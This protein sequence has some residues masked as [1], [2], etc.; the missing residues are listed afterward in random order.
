MNLSPMIFVA[1]FAVA[2]LFIK[3]APR[4]LVR[5]VARLFASAIGK[6]A[7][8]KVPQQIQ[9]SPTSSPAWKDATA[10]QQQASALVRTGFNDIGTYTIDKMPGVL[11][12]IL[13]QPTMYVAA[14][15]TEHPKAG[16]W[17]ELVTRYSDASSD[18]TTTL[19]DQG[20][21]SPPFV[22][23]NRANPGTPAES[24]YQQH[25]QQRKPNFIKHLSQDD[26]VHEFENAYMHYMIWMNDTGL[27]P[28]E[29]ARVALKWA[30]AKQQ[31]AGRS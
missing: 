28:E 30:R 5:V 26:V 4:L 22:R 1:V 21:M 27:N 12:R 11:V 14:H 20:L 9:L 2:F 13:F 16:N 19:P 18:L 10:I 7:L 25:L 6:D 15:I 24:V 31:A 3:I 23:N 29:I 8:A 17:L